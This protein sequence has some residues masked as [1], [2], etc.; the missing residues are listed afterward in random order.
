VIFFIFRLEFLSFTHPEEDT[1]MVRPV[2]ELTVKAKD[3]NGD[4]KIDFQEY[5]GDRGK[6][7]SK[8]WLVGEKER[9]DTDLDKNK[10]GSLDDAEIIG[11]IIPD[12]SEIATDEVNHLFAGSD[13][14]VD[15]QIL[16]KTIAGFLVSANK[17]VP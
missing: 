8:D 11:W 14:D 1:A 17:I 13:E 10:D 2:L 5:V 12:N 16:N 15:G 6:D 9:Y 3:R 4:G 7:Q